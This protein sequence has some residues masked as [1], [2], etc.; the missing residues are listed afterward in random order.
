MGDI[1]TSCTYTKMAEAIGFAKYYWLV[2]EAP[3][4]ADSGDTIAFESTKYGTFM[5]GFAG[6]V[7]SGSEETFAIALS[8]TT[9]T[10]TVGT[11]SNKARCYAL[12]MKK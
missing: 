10:I 8:S 5:G 3:A 4:T 11:G 12:L 7:T 9:Y 2:I 1:S 6:E